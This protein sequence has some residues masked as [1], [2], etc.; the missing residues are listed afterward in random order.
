[1]KH[2]VKFEDKQLLI[3]LSA[4]DAVESLMSSTFQAIWLSTHIIFSKPIPLEELI[5]FL[6]FL[7]YEYQGEIV[8]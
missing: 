4:A 6:Q 2:I 3:G 7:E 5:G 8:L 1:M